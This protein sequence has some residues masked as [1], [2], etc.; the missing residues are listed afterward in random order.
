MPL[1]GWLLQAASIPVILSTK[2]VILAAE[3][4]SGKTH[5]YLAPLIQKLHETPEEV[6]EVE[7][8]TGKKS[9]R[10]PRHFGLVMC[11]NALLCQQVADMANVLQSTGGDPLIRVVVVCGGQV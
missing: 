5:A 9:T 4:G 10:R 6:I 11:P 1:A 7:N 8:Q 2:D 3:T